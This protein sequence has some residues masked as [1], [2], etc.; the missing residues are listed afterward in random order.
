MNPTVDSRRNGTPMTTSYADPAAELALMKL[1]QRIRE[2][3]EEAPGL[4]VTVREGSRFWGLEERT[5]AEVLAR[6]LATGF[7]ARSA[8]DR[9]RQA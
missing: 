6:L 9:Y 1:A 4:R 2:E 3:F 8:D 5:C 7:L